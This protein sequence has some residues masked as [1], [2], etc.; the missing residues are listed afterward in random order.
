MVREQGELA[1][2]EPPWVCGGKKGR[3]SGK[4]LPPPLQ[5][6]KLELTKD[7]NTTIS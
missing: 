6:E 5:Q 7:E 4:P 1:T 2:G 3:W